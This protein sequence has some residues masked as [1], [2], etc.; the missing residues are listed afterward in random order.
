MLVWMQKSR[1]ARRKP[2]SG[3][4]PE[5]NAAT[6]KIADLAAVCYAL[7]MGRALAGQ[8]EEADSLKRRNLELLEQLVAEN[9]KSPR[10]RGELA[11]SLFRIGGRLP[12]SRS[13]EAE[14]AL[15]R[16]V[17]LEFE[18][19]EEFPTATLY[20]EYLAEH[21]RALAEFLAS[22]G[23]AEEAQSLLRKTLALIDEHPADATNTPSCRFDL[24]ELYAAFSAILRESGRTDEAAEAFASHRLVPV[25]H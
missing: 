22:S 13:Q 19:V 15:R 3:E 10:Y 5:S 14:T 17:A 6:Q 21:A 7:A 4:L 20:H 8:K 24:A 18:L 1:R 2:S 9:P 25:D 16:A 12:Q 11:W 23:R